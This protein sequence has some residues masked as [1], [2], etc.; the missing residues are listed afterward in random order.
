MSM[1]DE[2]GVGREP[3]TL[4]RAWDHPGLFAPHFKGDT[5][6][7]WRVYAKSLLGEPLDDEAERAIFRD[8]TGR[9]AIPTEPFSESCLVIGRRGGKSRMLALIAVYL[10]C[11]RSYGQYLAPGEVATIA[12]IA[13]DRK[14]ARSIF[15]YTLGM[16][17]A[18]R[19]LERFIEPKG[20]TSETIPLKNR[21]VIEIQ[22]AS[23]RVTRGYTFAA[24][25]ADETAFWKS[26]DSINPDVEI[27]RALRP[28]LST[29]P[30]AILLNA[31][32]PYRKSGELYKAWRRYY[33]KDDARVL[34]WQATTS[35]MN[36]SLDPAIIEDAYRDD[37]EAAS[38]EYGASFRSDISDFV[39][40]E[41]VDNVTVPG[42]LELPRAGGVSYYGFVDPSGGSGGDSMTLA[43]AHE[44]GGISVLD[45]LR[46]IR[47][48][49]SPE[50]AVGEFANTLKSYGISRVVG[51]RWGG[52]FVREPFRNA[53]I[54]YDL[55]DK[56]KSEVYQATLPL[57]NSAKLELLD[58]PRLIAQL[59]GLERRTSR[60]GR[61]SIDHG[62]GLHDDIAN[63][64]AGALLLASSGSSSFGWTDEALEGL[65]ALAAG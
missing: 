26:D 61:D 14:Q 30:G 21:V 22:T 45:L 1:A 59:C 58:H 64:A 27:F 3:W 29:I 31:S 51:D 23:F 6:K 36:P 40:R 17:R 25:L 38:A 55:S 28:G 52:E 15:R 37:P 19:V 44:R 11:F 60:S 35:T 65:A 62:P 54:Q 39:S 20:L 12:V 7:S 13:A 16:L 24:V 41:S 53:G 48:P 56:P 57:L 8:C 47:P 10:A 18:I 9:T 46:E 5:W 34:V 43:V 42:R 49:F 33:G 2:S 63:A 50:Q 4:T 32:S